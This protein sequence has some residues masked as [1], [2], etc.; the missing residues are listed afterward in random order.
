V[1]AGK[2]HVTRHRGRAQSDSLAAIVGIRTPGFTFAC[3]TRITS[4]NAGGDHDDGW[5]RS[6][7]YA[8]F[9]MHRPQEVRRNS[10][11]VAFGVCATIVLIGLMLVSIALGLDPDQTLSISAAFP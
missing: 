7:W 11:D 8:G 9:P 6:Q 4:Q 5:E 3:V 1:T 2:S 10:S